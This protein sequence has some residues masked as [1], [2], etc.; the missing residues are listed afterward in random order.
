MVVCQSGISDNARSLLL[1]CTFV[2]TKEADHA[3]RDRGSHT[4]A[5]TIF[6][7][8]AFVNS[9]NLSSSISSTAHTRQVSRSLKYNLGGD[10]LIQ[11]LKLI[12]RCGDVPG[13]SPAILRN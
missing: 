3:S 13:K 5:A 12:H 4:I 8:S 2:L 7:T 10:D 6:L 11:K 1:P 9:H